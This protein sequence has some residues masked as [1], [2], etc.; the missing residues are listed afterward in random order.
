[1]VAYP[2]LLQ[3]TDFV[4]PAGTGTRSPFLEEVSTAGTLINPSPEDY[5]AAQPSSRY[6]R[7]Q[8][9]SLVDATLATGRRS[10]SMF[11][12][13]TMTSSYAYERL[14]LTGSSRL[15]N[16][17]IYEGAKLIFRRSSHG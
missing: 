8:S 17:C 3:Q 7:I 6:F 5:L 13:T 15:G 11:G 9:I 12:L 2:I 10:V 4:I 14:A 1:M 16:A